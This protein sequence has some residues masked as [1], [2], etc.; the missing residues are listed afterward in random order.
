M[1]LL[2]L[3]YHNLNTNLF[4]FYL[5]A[6]KSPSIP[7]FALKINVSM[8]IGWSINYLICSKN[9]NKAKLTV[10]CQE[11]KQNRLRFNLLLI[12]STLF[13][14]IFN[15]YYLNIKGLQNSFFIQQ[16]K[17]RATT[18][19]FLFNTNNDFYIFSIITHQSGTWKQ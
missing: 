9:K 19:R 14:M 11:E 17:R 7:L 18:K 2:W 15:F 3:K 1:R 10:I 13:W 6:V 5:I 16:H 8:L 12:T 4:C